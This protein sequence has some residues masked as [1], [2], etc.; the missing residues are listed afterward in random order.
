MHIKSTVRGNLSINYWYQA[1]NPHSSGNQFN[2]CSSS[3]KI[4]DST[5]PFNEPPDIKYAFLKH[6]HFKSFEE[7]CI[8]LK[9]GRADLDNTDLISKLKDFYLKN[10]NDI[11]KIIIM[12][13]I[14]NLTFK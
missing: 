10:K 14:F 6:Y 8:K 4:I 5:S 12:N 3:G 7:Y 11:S 13:K 2:S 1:S 9:R